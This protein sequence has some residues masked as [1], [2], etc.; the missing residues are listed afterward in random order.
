[1]HFDAR[2]CELLIDALRQHRAEFDEE[3]Q[4][5]DKQPLHD[6]TSHGADAV[7]YY[8]VT[9]PRYTVTDWNESALGRFAS[10]DS[11]RMRRRAK[12]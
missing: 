7:R 5:Y 9:R 11:G 12:G 6:W 2:R 8:A 3:L 4:I 10:N 1:M